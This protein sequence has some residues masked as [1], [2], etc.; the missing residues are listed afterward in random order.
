MVYHCSAVH[1][2]FLRISRE[3]VLVHFI[4]VTTEWELLFYSSLQNSSH[5][6]G[7]DRPSPYAGGGS[8]G[9]AELPFQVNDIH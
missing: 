7:S 4:Q 9:S 2:K 1:Y 3:K 8:G 5:T 6:A